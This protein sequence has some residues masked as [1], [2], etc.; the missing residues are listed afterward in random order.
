MKLVRE[1]ILVSG[2]KVHNVGFRSAMEEMAKKR[3]VNGFVMNLR[4]GHQI[5]AILEGE[6]SAVEEII[7]WAEKGP[8]GAE[9]EKVNVFPQPYKGEYSHFKIIVP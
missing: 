6:E 9:I 5:K 7:K 4:N 2:E 8:P 1:V 3:H